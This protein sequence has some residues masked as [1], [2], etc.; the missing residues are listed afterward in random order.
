MLLSLILCHKDKQWHM[1]EKGDIQTP[2]F[3]DS[4]TIIINNISWIILEFSVYL[5][6]FSSV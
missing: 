6:E 5:Q 1:L 4:D 2:V 3:R